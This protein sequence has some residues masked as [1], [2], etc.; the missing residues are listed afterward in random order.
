[1]V[2]LICC[3]RAVKSSSVPPLHHWTVPSRLARTPQEIAF[4]F[5]KPGMFN[6][7]TIGSQCQGCCEPS[8]R[9]ILSGDNF[10]V[11]EMVLRAHH[12]AVGR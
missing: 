4:V 10:Q 3:S 8:Q 7:V 9:V 5:A 11:N 12:I 1:M 6:V 2:D